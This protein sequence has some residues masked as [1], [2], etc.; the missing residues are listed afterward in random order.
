MRKVTVFPALALLAVSTVGAVFAATPPAVPRKA[1]EFVIQMPDGKQTLLSSYRG[2][3]VVLAFMFTTCAHCQKAAPQ[4]AH[5]QD[6]YGAKGVQFLGATF[7]KEAQRDVAQFDKV[8]GVNFPCGF[9][10]EKNVL[11]FLG[12]PPG[13]PT[14]IPIVIFIDKTGTIRRI[15]M[16]QDSTQKDPEIE[17]F[18]TDV[19][20]GVKAE[21]DKMLKPVSAA[22]K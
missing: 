6:E 5:L 20:A 15:R 11:E 2:K 10:S 9:S 14:F 19:G 17:A 12:L 3:T 4:L 8:F 7:N 13:T 18:F 22:K 16:I 21:L 1:P